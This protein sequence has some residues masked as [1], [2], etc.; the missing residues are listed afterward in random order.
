MEAVMISR[1]TL[2]LLALTLLK[3]VT[4][5]DRLIVHEWGTFTTVSRADGSA[6]HW[7]PLLGPS[8]LPNFVYGAPNAREGFCP[9]CESTL[10]RMETPVLYFYSG[11]ELEVSVKVDFPSGKITE[12]FPQARATNPGIDW[13]RITVLPAAQVELPVDGKKSHYYPARETDA[14]TI[15]VETGMKNE[16]EKFLFY[17]GIGN[18]LPPLQ[19]R[20]AG[21]QLILKNVG[22]EAI[23]PVILFENRNG[24]RGW[25]ILDTL[26]AEGTLTRPAL[27]RSI[28][29]LGCELEEA[30]TAHGIFEKEA[31]AMVKTWRDSWFEEGLR[32]FYILPRKATDAILPITITPQPDQLARVFVGRSEIITPEI[33][34]EIQ[35]AAREFS[36]GSPEKRNAAINTIRRYGRFAEP[37][38]TE[39]MKSEYNP[40]IW[41]LVI[42]AR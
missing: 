39:M 22:S 17:R 5:G 26:K 32:I 3:P 42:A 20:L 18:F 31:R 35:A 15:R 16:H 29:S 24:Q 38:L 28:D 34:G 33:A 40:S 2:A 12:W 9:K 30:L 41:N 23:S 11:Q 36:Q 37:V 10:A 25:K 14:A 19:S 13:G 8:E 7:N 27:G 4:E 6:Y 1:I 21:D